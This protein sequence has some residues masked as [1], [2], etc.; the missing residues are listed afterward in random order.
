[1]NVRG[2]DANGAACRSAGARWVILLRRQQDG[3]IFVE[4]PR[5]KRKGSTTTFSVSVSKETRRRLKKAAERGY[6]GNVSALIEA[7]ALEAERQ[8]ALDRL[9]RDAPPIDEA[10][11]DAFVAELSAKPPAKRRRVA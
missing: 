5:L 9:L 7:V 4:M 6:G 11:Y 1:V 10:A 3:T 2:G 8:E